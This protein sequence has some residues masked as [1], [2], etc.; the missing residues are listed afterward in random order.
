MFRIHAYHF[1]ADNGNFISNGLTEGQSERCSLILPKEIKISSFENLL[2]IIYRRLAKVLTVAELVAHPTFRP[3]E[4]TPIPIKTLKDAC[5]TAHALGL[6]TFCRQ[7][8]NHII[9][10]DCVDESLDEA[11]PKY[12]LAVKFPDY[13][14]KNFKDKQVDKLCCAA[15]PM[16]HSHFYELGFSELGKVWKAALVARAGYD[17]QKTET[18]EPP[19]EPARA[20]Y[21]I[22]TKNSPGYRAIKRELFGC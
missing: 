20:S 17:G 1:L 21:L 14:P 2:S 6:F 12:T 22:K 7:I 18:Y 4:S 8:S 11:V 15:I 16:T 19:A 5:L 13:F 3:L 9:L 10:T